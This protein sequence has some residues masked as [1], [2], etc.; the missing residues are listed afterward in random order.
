MFNWLRNMWS[1]SAIVDD[2]KW[3]VLDDPLKHMPKPLI[4]YNRGLKM[5]EA[6]CPPTRHPMFVDYWGC[7]NTPK[8]AYDDY[9]ADFLEINNDY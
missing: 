1:K 8:Q 6:S 7:G 2:L 9:V 4:F 3:P 5:W